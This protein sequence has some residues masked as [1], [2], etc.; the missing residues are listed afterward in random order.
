MNKTVVV[1]DIRLFD[2]DKQEFVTIKGT[3]FKI[4]HSLVSL[5]KWEEKWHKPFLSKTQKTQ[6]ELIDYVR[7]MTITQNVNPEIY[8]YLPTSIMNEIIEYMNDPMTATTI[9]KN[10][11]RPPNRQ[12]ITAE[13]IYG[14]MIGLNIPM[15][16]QKWHLNKLMTLIEVVNEQN[17]PS[18]KMGKNATLAQNRSLN[19]A[20]RAALHTKG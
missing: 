14:W 7:C 8:N 6:E 18:K 13:V 5:S 19:A 20:R 16:F 12:I 3:T 1:P 2:D 4:Q 10:D 17:A 15:E 11:N 9:K